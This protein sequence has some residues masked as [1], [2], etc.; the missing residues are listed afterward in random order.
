VSANVKQ[1]STGQGSVALCDQVCEWLEYSQT[2]F[3]DNLY[4]KSNLY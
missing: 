2:C 4:L 3:S 1:E